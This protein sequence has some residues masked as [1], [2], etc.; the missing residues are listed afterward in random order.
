MMVCVPPGIGPGQMFQV[1]VPIQP[2]V[3]M[4]SPAH[5][6]RQRSRNMPEYKH[7]PMPSHSYKPEYNEVQLEVIEARGLLNSDVGMFSRGKSDPYCVVKDVKG[8]IGDG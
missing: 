8:L 7:S 1:D 2:S 6:F 5:I 3:P 4:P